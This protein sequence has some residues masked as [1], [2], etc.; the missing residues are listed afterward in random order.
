MEGSVLGGVKGGASL[1]R[2]RLP[3][4]SCSELEPR[5][6]LDGPVKIEI[7][8]VVMDPGVAA[9]AKIRGVG[10]DR[11]ERSAPVGA[12][13][14]EQGRRDDAGGPS[15]G[16]DLL[17]GDGVAGAVLCDPPLDRGP[18]TARTADRTSR[19]S[20]TFRPRR[21]KSRASDRTR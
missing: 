8:R 20:R 5:R 3:N 17:A 16:P 18:G 21:W 1:T 4:C 14:T 9:A 15:D 2:K 19:G 13:R 11:I 7:P 10:E 6:E 12:E